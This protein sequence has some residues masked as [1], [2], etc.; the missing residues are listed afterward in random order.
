MWLYNAAAWLRR[1]EGHLGVNSVIYGLAT[2]W[3]V[4]HIVHHWRD[5]PLAPIAEIETADGL[6]E[7]A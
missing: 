6:E 2:I 3:E 5:R 1:R 7:V 4:E